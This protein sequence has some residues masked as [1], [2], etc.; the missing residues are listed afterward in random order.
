MEKKPIKLK[1]QYLYFDNIK[2]PLKTETG[3]TLF[4]FDYSLGLE[5]I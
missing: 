4:L 3:N 2:F 1:E 5:K